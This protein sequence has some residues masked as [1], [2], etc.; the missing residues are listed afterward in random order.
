REHADAAHRRRRRRAGLRDEP[1]SVRPDEL[2]A[3]NGD[4]S[5]RQPS[6]RGAGD[7][8]AGG[9]AGARLVRPLAARAVRKSRI[10][11]AL[12]AAVVAAA[13]AMTW[14]TTRGGLSAHERPGAIETL[15]ARQLRHWATP[16]RLRDAKNPVA[17][18]P[19]VLADGRAHFADH[20]AVCHGNDG[21][22]QTGAEMFP[23]APDMTRPSTQ[24]LTDGELFSIIENGIRMTGMPAW[25]GAH[26]QTD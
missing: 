25:G 11:A 2:R 9:G 10:A 13:F 22:G 19:Q 18:S 23:P 1:G 17:L 14:S 20:C 5:R 24:A 4:R 21:R 8:G 26:T 7:A 15:L 12:I 3:A 16:A 6:G